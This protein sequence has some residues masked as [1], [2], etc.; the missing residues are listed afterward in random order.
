[1]KNPMKNLTTIDLSDNLNLTLIYNKS[2]FSPPMLKQVKMSNTSLD[3]IRQIKSWLDVN[4]LESIDFSNNNLSL[5]AST[6][7]IFG[8][9]INLKELYL[10][11]IG[12]E[13]IDIIQLDRLQLLV[14]LDLSSNSL[15]SFQC[16]LISQLVNLELLDLSNNFASSIDGCLMFKSNLKYLYLNNN[17]IGSL[18]LND[19]PNLIQVDLSH[20]YFESFPVFSFDLV[21]YTHVSTLVSIDLSSNRIHKLPPNE[22]YKLKSAKSVNLAYNL[23][24]TLE[25]AVFEQFL[26]LEYLSLAYN[27]LTFI[28]EKTFANLISLKYLNLSSND[29]K[30]IASRS[31]QTLDKL[32]LLNISNISLP[33]LDVSIFEGMSYLKDMYFKGNSV[34]GVTIQSIF[35]SISMM[36]FYEI[37]KIF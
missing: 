20:N 34:I 9:L 36:I 29:I 18:G 8:T 21:R 35:L 28:G 16:E 7:A 27:R 6:A 22:M 30:S 14:R 37:N 24:E 12:L 5:N 4:R 25:D 1:M 15:N 23:L 31:F 33:S 32:E 3:S 11:S 10:S 17:R 19:V 2:D 13:S 26:E